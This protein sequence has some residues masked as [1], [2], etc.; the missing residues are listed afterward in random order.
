MPAKSPKRSKR[1][2]LMNPNLTDEDISRICKEQYGSI[3]GTD[4]AVKLT[5]AVLAINKGIYPELISE[6]SSGSYLVKN[7]GKEKIAVF[8]PKDEEPYGEL[9]P[10]FMKWIQR[11]CCPCCFGRSCLVPNQGYLCEAGASLV[12]QK[13]SLNIVPKTAVVS[14]SSPTFNYTRVDRAMA[15]TKER[16]SYRFV[17]P[18]KNIR[19]I[20]LP[21]K[22]GSFQL[23]VNGYQEGNYLIRQ[24]EL[25]PEKSPPPSVMAE[26][27]L[28]FEKMVI[29]D[30]LIRNTD[31]GNNWLI[32]YNPGMEMKN[33][34]DLVVESSSDSKLIEH[35]EENNNVSIKIAAID[36]GLAFPFKHP[37]ECRAYPFHWADLLIAQR[38]F[39]E[40]IV[41]KILPLVDNTDFV[42]ELGNEL[43]KIFESDK[44][45]KKR[46]FSKQLSVIRGQM[47][48]LREALRKRKSPA[49]LVQMTPVCMIEIE[50]KKKRKFPKFSKK[51][52]Q[53]NEEKQ[54]QNNVVDDSP[55]DVDDEL[56][57]PKSWRNIFKQKIQR[58][59][60]LFKMC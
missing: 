12:D 60:P 27:Q 54:I 42:K 44:G 17:R 6:G 55:K 31:R 26:F 22:R 46:I 59:S 48:N 16:I 30:Y 51:G 15:R 9:N 52:K 18:S 13:L 50:T 10:K 1:V 11:M 49:Q 37:D 4:F 8:K 58:R 23:F 29:L 7:L 5:E 43:R 33:N 38:P 35:D 14:L 19:H 40:E 36:N 57:N 53:E 2:N 25:F 39:S 3:P 24:W 45:F 28:E 21:R 32:K 41:N 20:G 47:F 34:Q 56:A